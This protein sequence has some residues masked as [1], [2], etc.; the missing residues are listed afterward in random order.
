MIIAAPRRDPLAYQDTGNPVSSALTFHNLL[1][2]FVS[3]DAR[4]DFAGFCFTKYL[5]LTPF[6]SGEE[7]R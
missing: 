6:T 4:D 3:Q 1:A 2:A 7:A 5:P